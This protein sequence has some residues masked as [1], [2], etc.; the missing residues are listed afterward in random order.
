MS[1]K[2]DPNNYM[3]FQ[4]RGDVTRSSKTTKT[5]TLNQDTTSTPCTDLRFCLVAYMQTKNALW[6]RDLLPC[7]CSHVCCRQ[8]L[9]FEPNF[10]KWLSIT[11]ESYISTFTTKHLLPTRSTRGSQ[12]R[13]LL[14]LPF[15]PNNLLIIVE[16]VVVIK[17]NDSTANTK[18]RIHTGQFCIYIHENKRKHYVPAISV[19]PSVCSHVRS[20]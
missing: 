17:Y 6:I 7:V 12:A 11:Q 4:Q 18:Q 10:G 8:S 16:N 15:L 14:R 2:I 19:R 20:L 9:R 13:L 1:L 3:R 5:E